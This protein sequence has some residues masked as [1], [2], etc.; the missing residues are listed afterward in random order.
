MEITENWFFTIRVADIHS[1]KIL[2]LIGIWASSSVF[3]TLTLTVSEAIQQ[4][5]LR[6]TNAGVTFRFQNRIVAHRENFIHYFILASPQH[7]NSAQFGDL[8]K[9][10]NLTVKDVVTPEFLPSPLS[11][12]LKSIISFQTNHVARILE[13]ILLI[14]MCFQLPSSY[15][16]CH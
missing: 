3:P 6:R 14:P 7:T 13:N 16:T 8:Q 15:N 10:L 9:E 11:S 2:L 12:I 5:V 4:R 1:F